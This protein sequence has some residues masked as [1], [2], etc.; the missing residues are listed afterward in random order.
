MWV[1]PVAVLVAMTVAP[2]TA[3]PVASVTVPLMPPRKVWARRGETNAIRATKAKKLC[4]C[5]LHKQS[6]PK[7]RDRAARPT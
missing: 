3:A 1:T 2:A 6:P 5:S 7:I 4:G